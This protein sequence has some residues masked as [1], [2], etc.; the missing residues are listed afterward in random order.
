LPSSK[1]RSNLIKFLTQDW[2][3][4]SLRAKLLNKDMYVTC[5]RKC[6]RVTE[7]TWSEV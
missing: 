1:S 6:F 3:K 7:G 5:E 4:Q 2:Q